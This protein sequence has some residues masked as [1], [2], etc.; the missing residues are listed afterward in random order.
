MLKQNVGWLRRRWPMAVLGLLVGLLPPRGEAEATFTLS[1]QPAGGQAR[2]AWPAL[3]GGGWAY[4]VEC[5]TSLV[6]G[7]WGPVAPADAWP[8]SGVSCVTAPDARAAFYRVRAANRGRLVE[9]RLLRTVTTFEMNMLLIAYQITG[10]TPRY[11]VRIYRILYE[12]F[13][14]RGL[15][16]LASGALVVPV[17]AP[18]SLPLVSY[19]HGTQFEQTD[20]PSNPDASDQLFG[21]IMATDGYAVTL[22]DYLGLGTN[23][24]ALH[25]YLHARSEA[26]AAVD[27][28]RA[29]RAYMTNTLALH[30]NGKLFL[31]GYSQGGHATLALQRELEDRHAVEFPLTASAPMAGPHDLSGTMA[32]KIIGLEAYGDPAYVPYLLFGYNAV[33]RMFAAPAEVLMEP[34]AT[35]L[36]PLFDGRHASSEINA[37][38]P[39]VP[40]LIFKPAYMD[41]FATDSNHIFRAA[42]RCNDTYRWKPRAPIRLYHCPADTIVPFANSQVACS[43][44]LANGAT[45]VQVLDPTPG[46]DH[47]HGDGA[48]P[49]FTA[50]KAWFDSLR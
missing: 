15:S 49:C 39:A 9:T 5:R 10:I 12:T 31:A 18:G 23:S 37:V 8:T 33:Y 36:P 14:P 13:D 44:L 46:T 38:M 20:A 17:G 45:S 3:N 42:L 48:L 41:A 32:E 50:A 26:T 40:G 28:L 25:P 24:P 34:Y 47:D 6:F 16:T 19:Q 4:G 21:V 29:G 30:L 11:N 1:I 43:N 35:Q 2:L 22:A 27:M 7:A